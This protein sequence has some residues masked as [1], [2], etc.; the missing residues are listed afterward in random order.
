MNIGIFG[1]T[2]DP[3]HNGHIN[4]AKNIL[5]N[6]IIDKITFVPA[7]FPPHKPN[8]P[9]TKFDFRY[10]MVRLAIEGNKKFELSD[11]ENNGK[12]IPSYTIDTIK[13][14]KEKYI[15]DKIHVIIGEDSLKQLHTWYKANELTKECCFIAYPRPGENI[16]IE[17]LK[18]YWDN[19]T[20]AK[21][22][23]SL[24]KFEMNDISSTEIRKNIQDGNI[25][26]IKNMVPQKV[27]E[28]IFAKGLYC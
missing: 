7:L 11:I 2:F 26:A 15:D 13:K 21:L 9:I 6:S 20:A 14:I 16:T 28:F 12:R 22:L 4:L 8:A 23:D 24:L 18:R 19:D 17:Y 10:E 1:G 5:S 27:Y 25:K 3:P